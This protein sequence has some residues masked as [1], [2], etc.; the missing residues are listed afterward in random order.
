M[1]ETNE[2]ELVKLNELINNLSQELNKNKLLLKNLKF[3][4]NEIK[5]DLL[6]LT[7][8][9]S[10]KRF[11]ADL[12]QE[13][14]EYECEKVNAQLLIENQNLKLENRNLNNTLKDYESTLEFLMNKFRNLIYL[15]KLHELNLIKH[16]ELNNDNERGYNEFSYNDSSIN[17]NDNDND[18]EKVNLTQKLNLINLKNLIELTLNDLE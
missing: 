14:F 15:N 8:G 17:D 3:N 6:H 12:S 13:Q 18:N 4:S 11:N 16:Y 9:I 7:N 2:N 1:K 5:G 10:L